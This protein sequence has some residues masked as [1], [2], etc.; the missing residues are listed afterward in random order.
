MNVS[1]NNRNDFESKSIRLLRAAGVG[2]MYFLIAAGFF[3]CGYKIGMSSVTMVA[4]QPETISSTPVPEN[5]NIYMLK[6]E[7]GRLCLYCVGEN[8]QTLIAGEEVSTE[9]FP[10]EDRK[11]LEEGIE[12]NN[13]GEAQASFEDFIS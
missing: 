8:G 2:L 5:K 9:I 10:A 4:A 13:L 3:Y 12:F 7:N 1:S 6:A 11:M